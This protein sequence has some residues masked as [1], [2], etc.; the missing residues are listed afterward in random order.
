[1]R[2]PHLPCEFTLKTVRNSCKI[3]FGN[4]EIKHLG[5]FENF[6]GHK[7]RLIHTSINTMLAE[8]YSVYD[9]NIAFHSLCISVWFAGTA[10]VCN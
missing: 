8:T 4:T 1:M 10:R 3:T 9:V 7:F 2:Y 5:S 6:C